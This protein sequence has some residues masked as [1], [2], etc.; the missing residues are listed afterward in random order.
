[1]LPEVGQDGQAKLVHARV[2]VVGLG[3]RGCAAASYLAAAGVG[4]IGV[5]DPDRVALEDLHRQLLYREG[6]IGRLKVDIAAHALSNLAPGVVVDVYEA[7][8][9]SPRSAELIENYDVVIDATSRVTAHHAV[10][11]VSRNTSRPNVFGSIQGFEG[12]LTVFAGDGPC[13][14]CIYP[15]AVQEGAA[16]TSASG[17]LG[18]A[19]GI[20]GTWQALEAL[21]I[22]LGAGKP[23][24]GRLLRFDGLTG[25]VSVEQ[26]SKR[27]GCSVCAG[28]SVEIEE[29]PASTSLVEEI[30][31]QTL[32]SE[33][34]SKRPPKLLDVREDS[35]L[36]IS[37]LKFDY[38]IPVGELLDRV[39]ELKPSDD[40]V[41]YCRSGAKS[42]SA[43]AFLAKRGFK[44]VRNLKGGIIAWAREVDPALA[45][46]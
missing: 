41:V 11:E 13:Y 16:S 1:V 32:S 26:V 6:D 17:V 7:A 24:M 22:L 20:I 19:A 27:E 36:A 3:G 23:L 10:N 15:E 8:V 30:D 38:H 28:G 31:V 46:Y 25:D 33:L 43:A 21:K 5:V 40:L 44:R 37:K 14:S 4:R 2:L 39:S 29:Q 18:A 12:E 35:E 9:T 34:K 42:A 45:V